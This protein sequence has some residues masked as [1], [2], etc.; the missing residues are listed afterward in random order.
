MKRDW[1]ISSKDT[2]SLDGSELDFLSVRICNE[3]RAIRLSNEDFFKKNQ[4]KKY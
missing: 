1:E 2:H 4:E 3:I